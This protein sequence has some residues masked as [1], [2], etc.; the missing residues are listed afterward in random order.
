MDKGRYIVFR[1][2]WVAL[3]AVVA[4]FGVLG[5]AWGIVRAQSRTVETNDASTVFTPAHRSLGEAARHFF[6][7]RAVPVQPVPFPHH[8]HIEQQ[9]DCEVCHA[10]AGMGAVAGLPSLETCM[11]CHIGIAEDKPTIVE[12]TALYDKGLDLHWQRVYGWTEE[13]HVRFNHAPHLRAEVA[14][15]ACHGDLSRMTVAERAVDHTMEFCVDCH[16]EKEVSTDCLT[17][18]Y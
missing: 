7:I 3:T 18:H 4:V 1:S 10:G 2:G 6:G 12:I 16:R 14:C 9:I 15:S 8:T 13:A 17:C 5:A 11:N